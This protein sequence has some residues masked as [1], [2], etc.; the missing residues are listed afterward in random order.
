MNKPVGWTMGWGFD[1]Q[2]L[3]EGGKVLFSSEADR[4]LYPEYFDENKKPVINE[5]CNIITEEKFYK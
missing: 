1:L 3:F 2:L 4:I 5:K